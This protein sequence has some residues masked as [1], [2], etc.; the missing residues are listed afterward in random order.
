MYTGTNHQPAEVYL[1]APRIGKWPS[2]F[3]RPHHRWRPSV[4]ASIVR[5]SKTR[6]DLQQHDSF[7]WNQLLVGGFKQFFYFVH[8][9]WDN[10]S[11]WLSSFFSRWLKPPT[12]L[13]LFRIFRW[14][15]VFDKG[16]VF[17]CTCLLHR[18]GKI[19]DGRRKIFCFFFCMATF[20]NLILSTRCLLYKHYCWH[21]KSDLDIL[22]CIFICIHIYIHVCVKNTHTHIVSSL[23]IVSLA[24]RLRL[25]LKR[26]PNWRWGSCR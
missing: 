9:I 6:V 8:N 1:L 24:Y 12:R 7:I 11:H 2:T 14:T 4:G 18:A 20:P 15:L 22:W 26:T 13:T 17:F 5:W 19:R 21:S 10:P 25:E 16:T 23:S 3:G